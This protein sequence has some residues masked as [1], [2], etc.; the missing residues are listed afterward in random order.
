V[1]E[2]MRIFSSVTVPGLFSNNPS[3]DKVVSYDP[4]YANSLS[5]IVAGGFTGASFYYSASGEFSV[6]VIDKDFNN[7]GFYTF[8]AQRQDGCNESFACNWSLATLDFTGVG[9]QIYFLGAANSAYDDF[10]FTLPGAPPTGGVPEPAQWAM[11]IAGFG[12]V[13]TALRRGRIKAAFTPFPL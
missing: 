5:L 4:R 2:T 11:L 3:G 8:T 6:G 12:L 1:N 13:G 7:L 9:A 10:T